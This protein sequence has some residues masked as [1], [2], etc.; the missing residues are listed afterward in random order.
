MYIAIAEWVA[1]TPP[2]GTPGWTGGDAMDPRLAQAAA[3]RTRTAIAGTDPVAIDWWA[4][5]NVLGP[6]ADG[7]GGPGAPISTSEI[8]TVSSRDFCATTER[9]QAAARWTSR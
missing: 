7:I 1:I 8:R 2:D 9:S 6:I 3:H 5:R 4:A